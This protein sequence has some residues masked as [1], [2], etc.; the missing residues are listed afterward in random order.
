MS[1]YHGFLESDKGV[2][3][4]AGHRFIRAAAQTY[5]GSIAVEIRDGQ[6]T[7]FAGQGSNAHPPNKIGEFGLA[8]LL[9]ADK[10][11]AERTGGQQ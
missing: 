8:D 10:L 3:T 7:I 5:D 2:T 11:V 4:R 1:K 9:V 6:V